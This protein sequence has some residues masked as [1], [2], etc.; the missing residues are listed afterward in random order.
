MLKIKSELKINNNLEKII[1]SFK[2]PIFWKEKD[3]VKQQIKVLDSKK[4]ENL[5]IDTNDLEYQIKKNPSIST[6]LLTNFIL[7]KTLEANNS[8]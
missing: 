2:P 8:L 6:L 4:I 7:E 3:I 1:S 5:I